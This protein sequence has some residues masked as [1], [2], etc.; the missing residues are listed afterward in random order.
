MDALSCSKNP[1]NSTNRRTFLKTMLATGTAPL[2]VPSITSADHHEHTFQ[3]GACDWSIKKML[4]L[5]AFHH[6]KQVGLNG[7]Q[8]SFGVKGEG[9][10]L[11]DRKNRDAIRQTVKQQNDNTLYF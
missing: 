4:D 8:Y 2:V 5:D 6:G 7:I 10:D 1:A 9:T 3:I 11:R